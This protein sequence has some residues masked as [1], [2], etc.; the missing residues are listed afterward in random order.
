MKKNTQSVVR[1]ALLAAGVIVTGAVVQA[2]PV[3]V[4]TINGYYDVDGYDTPSLH[5]DNSSAY[6]FTNAQLKLTG[7]QG[8]NNGVTESFSIANVAAGT[9]GIVAWG[10]DSRSPGQLFTNDYDDEYSG[11]FSAQT[12]FG[13][14]S[15]HTLVAAPQCAPQAN[16]YGWNYCADVGNVYVTFTAKWNGQNVYSQ[17]S[18]DPTVPGA[19]NAAGVFVGWEGLDPAGW[20]ETTY[21]S[22]SSGG[23]NGVLANIYLGTPPTVGSAPEP[24]SI[25][26]MGSGLLAVALIYRRKLA[27]R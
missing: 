13:L 26:L 3:V 23:P 22:H 17:F 8:L 15:S 16:I 19:G 25:A 18:P 20:A 24:M 11:S 21:D 7:Y 14:S 4:A 27:Q 1:A 6:D 10:S 2:D 9:T 5:I 12:G